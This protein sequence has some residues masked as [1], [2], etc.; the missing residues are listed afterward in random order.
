MLLVHYA[1][2]RALRKIR[3]NGIAPSH[4]RGRASGVYAFPLLPGVPRTVSRLWARLLRKVGRQ[5]RLSAV[6]FRIP[7]EEPVLFFRDFTENGFGKGTETT[8]G[9]TGKALLEDIKKTQASTFEAWLAEEGFAEGE[10]K[11][12]RE[13]FD[14]LRKE[15]Q[16]FRDGW[17]SGAPEVV[18]PR[19]IRPD[20]VIRIDV[21]RE[22]R[23]PRG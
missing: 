2:E 14:D 11:R 22:K 17:L 3:C 8:A 16:A 10:L 18:I 23:S 20:E 21:L 7:D 15:H 13:V 5:V 4:R 19:R 12:H 1:P 9:A 6:V